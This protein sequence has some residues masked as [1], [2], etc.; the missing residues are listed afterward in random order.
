[1]NTD[2]K[3][4]L[5]RNQL[6]LSNKIYEMQ[7]TLSNV[8]FTLLNKQLVIDQDELSDMILVSNSIL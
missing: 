1:M 8:P 5:E 4:Y 2:K 6:N 7:Q 3:V